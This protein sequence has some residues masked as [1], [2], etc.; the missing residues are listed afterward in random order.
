MTSVLIRLT[1]VGFQD[2]RWRCMIRE[3]AWIL[4]SIYNWEAIWNVNIK[5]ML[6]THF[7]FGWLLG[8]CNEAASWSSAMLGDSLLRKDAD[9][10]KRDWIVRVQRL[11]Q[12]DTFIQ[13]D[14]EFWFP[15]NCGKTLAIKMSPETV[16]IKMCP[17]TV[18]GLCNKDVPRNSSK[19]L[20]SV[21]PQKQWED[22]LAASEL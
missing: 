20:Q 3:V 16:V 12:K 21:C 17:E 9:L 19:N 5:T 14:T 6:F 18:V 1:S 13:I 7:L 10:G 4:C 22:S 2:L 11:K 15:R 8:I